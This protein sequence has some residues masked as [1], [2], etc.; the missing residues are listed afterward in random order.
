MAY[1]SSAN[2]SVL[3]GGVGQAVGVGSDDTWL[4]TGIDW[5]SYGNG[6][7][8]GRYVAGM[9][10]NQADG[11]VNLIGGDDGKGNALSDNWQ[12]TGSWTQVMPVQNYAARQDFGIADDAAND[13]IVAIYV[14]RNPDK[15]RHIRDRAVH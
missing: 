15:L 14:M 5:L 9:A 10:F 4:Y 8:P 2:G 11:G 12:W 7:P 1:D 13:K 3:F 6:G